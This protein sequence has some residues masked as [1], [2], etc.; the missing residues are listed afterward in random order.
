MSLCDILRWRKHDTS[1]SLAGKLKHGGMK[2]FVKL[3]L[4]G[5][6]SL[7]LEWWCFEVLGKLI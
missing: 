1:Q 4:A 5:I 2:G 3:S 6:G 7:C